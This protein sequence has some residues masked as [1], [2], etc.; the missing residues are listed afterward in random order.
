VP[1]GVLFS[2]RPK[3]QLAFSS[4]LKFVFCW[5]E[6]QVRIISTSTLEFFMTEDLMKQYYKK[7]MKC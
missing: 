5:Q 1:S 7:T 4:L 3:N 2:Q 6:K